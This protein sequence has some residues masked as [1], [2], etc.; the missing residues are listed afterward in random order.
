MNPLQERLQAFL[1][2][3][4]ISLRAFERQCDI[5][6]GTASKMTEKSYG[7]TFHKI[8]KAYPQLNV[9]WLKTGEGEM[10][11]PQPSVDID[12]DLKLCGHSQ[13][14]MRDITNIGDAK[15]QI[16]LLRERIK[17]LEKELHAKLCEL[18]EKDK[19]IDE[20]NASLERERKMNDYLMA[21]K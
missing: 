5:K 20:L 10:L 3:E 1:N 14:A 18:E 12:V 17:S 11:N 15:T 19:R 7:T 6:A 8:A 2:H 21:K 4:D 16:L 13:F 9:E